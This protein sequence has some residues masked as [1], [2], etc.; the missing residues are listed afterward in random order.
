VKLS[1]LNLLK[2]GDGIQIS[3][4]LLT[5]YETSETYMCPLPGEEVSNRL[6]TLDMD[7]EDWQT[8]IRQSDLQ[9]V[10][11]NGTVNGKMKKIILR[12]SS[13]Q[14]D[15]GVSWRVFKRDEYT[16]R[17][18]GKDDLPLTVDHL[19]LWKNGG[20]S[21][22]ENLVTSCK[23]CNKLRGDIE[24]ID[25]LKSDKYLELCTGVSPE[26]QMLNNFIVDGLDEIPIRLHI[27]SRGKKKKR[28]R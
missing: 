7:S 8:F 15:Q 27:P 9:E 26:F 19:V 24:Y 12:K 2:I 6:Y 16:C 11:V 23:R 5:D 22:E 18:C 4:I 1:D 10:E 25:W 17:Y 14:I 3:G 13:R 21:I 28:S 20:P